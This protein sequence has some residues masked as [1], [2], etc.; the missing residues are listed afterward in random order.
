VVKSERHRKLTY[1][2]QV[3]ARDGY[4]LSMKIA[5]GTHTYCS[6][7]DTK[8]D[9]PAYAQAQVT[10]PLCAKSGHRSVFVGGHWPLNDALL[11]ELDRTDPDR[12]GVERVFKAQQDAMEFKEKAQQWEITHNADAAFRERFNRL[13]GIPQVGRTKIMDGTSFGNF[14]KQE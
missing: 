12:G 14:G 4:L 1:E 6:R 13:V 2:N 10:C 11:H 7:C 3:R 8:L 5:P 9:V